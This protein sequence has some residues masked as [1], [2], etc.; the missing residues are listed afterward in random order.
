M[1]TLF[2]PSLDSA[3]FVYTD[4][5][6]SSHHG[7][8]IMTDAIDTLLNEWAIPRMNVHKIL[9][10]TFT[11]NKGSVRVFEKNGFTLT[12]TIDNHLTKKELVYGIHVLEW[13]RPLEEDPGQST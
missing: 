1:G 5:L 13:T 10:G 9:V 12:R 3:D 8:G 7:R 6:A 11:G 2:I 4:F